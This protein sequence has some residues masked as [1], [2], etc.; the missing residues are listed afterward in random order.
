MRN[1]MIDGKHKYSFQDIATELD[2]WVS[3]VY[4]IWK[5]DKETAVKTPYAEED[6]SDLKETD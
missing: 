3:Q 4:K 1:E 2:M 6:Y 5:R